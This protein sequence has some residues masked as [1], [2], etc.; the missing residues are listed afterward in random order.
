MEG[1]RG[2]GRARP[3]AP[4]AVT[5]PGAEHRPGTP[6][7]WKFAGPDAPGGHDATP[8]TRGDRR[9]AHGE[10]PPTIPPTAAV[11]AGSS[12]SPPVSRCRRRSWHFGCVREWPRES[13]LLRV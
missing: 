9:L 13:G 1:V 7:I 4:A 3:V 5:P 10:F 2:S 8:A 11:G 6:A 12:R